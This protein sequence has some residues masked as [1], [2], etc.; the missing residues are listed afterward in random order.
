MQFG[1]GYGLLLSLWFYL[2]C[3]GFYVALIQEC[4]NMR[5]GADYSTPRGGI[6]LA[7]SCEIQRIC[8]RLGTAWGQHQPEALLEGGI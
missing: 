7:V 3:V 2:L 1:T 6:F 4:G 5:G 8:P